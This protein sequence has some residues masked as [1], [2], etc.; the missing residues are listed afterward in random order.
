VIL[1]DDKAS[2][3]PVTGLFKT[4]MNK[5]SKS[6]RPLVIDKIATQFRVHTFAQRR[7]CSPGG[8]PFYQCLAVLPPETPNDQVVDKLRGI[9]KLLAG[10]GVLAVEPTSVHFH[11]AVK[12]VMGVN[13]NAATA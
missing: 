2:T 3:L 8:E 4:K 6:N 13:P 10:F 12:W 7:T 11:H 1:G 5:S 9:R